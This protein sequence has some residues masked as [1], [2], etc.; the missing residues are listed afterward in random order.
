[1]PESVHISYAGPLGTWTASGAAARQRLSD[2]LVEEGPWGRQLRGEEQMH[3]RTVVVTTTHEAA[4]RERVDRLVVMGFNADGR[5]GHLGYT[6][7]PVPVPG[8]QQ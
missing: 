4:T 7:F 2:A 1:M 5:V 8:D 3:G 6:R